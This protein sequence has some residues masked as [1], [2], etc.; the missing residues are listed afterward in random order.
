MIG[1]E[2]SWKLGGLGPK[3]WNK[4]KYC[5]IVPPAFKKGRKEDRETPGLSAYLDT[6]DGGGMDNF[7]YNSKMY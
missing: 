7:E 6:G 1:F 5:I 3:G 4:T 2:M